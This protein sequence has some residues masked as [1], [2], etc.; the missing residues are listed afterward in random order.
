[1]N[2]AILLRVGLDK[3]SGGSLAPIYPDGSFE[4]IPIPE[5]KK[6]STPDSYDNT[7]TKK[8][9]KLMSEFVPLKTK[10]LPLHSDPEFK[11]WSYGESAHPKI[12][13]ML[14][15][16]KGDLL[17]FYAGLQPDSPVDELSRIFII[18]YFIVQ[19]TTYL[20]HLNPD[21]YPSLRRKLGNNS[22]LF[23]L[24]PDRELVIVSGHKKESRVLDKA[25]PLSDAGLHHPFVL[26]DLNCGYKGSLLRAVGH[27]L[28]DDGFEFIQNYLSEGISALV[29]EKSRLFCYTLTNDSGFAPNTSSGRLTLATCKPKIRKAAQIGDWIM[30]MHSVRDGDESICFLSRVSETLTF[31]QYFNDKRFSGKHLHSDPNGDAIYY[32]D[33]ESFVQIIN[34][35]HSPQH[36]SRDISVDRVLICSLFWYFGKEGFSSKL[37]SKTLSWKIRGHR[38]IK[39]YKLIKSIVDLISSNH[40]IGV[41]ALP[42]HNRRMPLLKNIGTS[43]N[44]KNV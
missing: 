36:Y 6:T 16:D 8:S 20:E 3:G 14:T 35:H 37:T 33:G 21:E 28:K 39:D 22:H 42:T 7:V 23:R 44:N 19:K 1:M 10:S 2:K 31:D 9:G 5:N 30:G 25:L 34:P 12:D 40:R 24:D 38:V 4:W 29:T 27:T 32:F 18:A 15:L 43:L 41:H 26:P 11:T 13:Q 17:I